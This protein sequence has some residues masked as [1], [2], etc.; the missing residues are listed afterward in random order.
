[1]DS[2]WVQCNLDDEEEEEEEEADRII[3]PDYMPPRLVF[4]TSFK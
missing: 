4:E 3:D 2:A 1:M